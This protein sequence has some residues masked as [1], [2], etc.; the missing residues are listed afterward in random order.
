M[1]SGASSGSPNGPPPNTHGGCQGDLAEG[2]GPK[3]GRDSGRPNRPR[4]MA[5]ALPGGSRKS[6][7]KKS[8]MKIYVLLNAFK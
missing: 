5:A 6:C 3:R 4:Y 1:P 2:K 8:F 7:K